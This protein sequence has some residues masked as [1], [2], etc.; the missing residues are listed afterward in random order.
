MAMTNALAYF[1]AAQVMTEK[2]FF[3]FSSW[4]EMTFLQMPLKIEERRILN[5]SSF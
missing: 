3:N 2:S 5:F 1:V 4:L